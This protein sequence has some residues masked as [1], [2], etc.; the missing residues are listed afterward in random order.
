MRIC[1]AGVGSVRWLLCAIVIRMIVLPT[2]ALTMIAILLAGRSFSQAE[3]EASRIKKPLIYQIGNVVRL[4][5]EGP[6]PLLRALDALHEK[7]GW[8]VDYEDP[9]Y[10]AEAEGAKI[11][12]SLPQRRHTNARSSR[13]ESFSVEFNVDPAPDSRPDENSVLTTVV[14]AYNQGNAVA[15]F[16]LRK[17]NDKEHDGRF[18]VVGIDVHGQNDE[19][20]RQQPILDL[21]ITLTTEPRSAAQTIVLICRKVSGQNDVPVTSVI[22]DNLRGNGTVTVGGIEVKARTMLSRTLAS[23]GDRLS[24]RLL[25]DSSGKSYELSIIGLSQ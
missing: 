8:I 15:Q 3:R 23:M 24:W 1:R 13:G 4:H 17:E 18:D 6:R 16:E 14:N 7:Y 2:I 20:Q 12:Q 5:A 19:T 11:P 10:P 21:P 25:Y 22:A 9:E